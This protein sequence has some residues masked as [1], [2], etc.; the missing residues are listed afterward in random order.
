M[1]FFYI[2]IYFLIYCVKKP[3][4][5]G[6]NVSIKKF[7]FLSLIVKCNCKKLSYIAQIEIYYFHTSDR[8]NAKTERKY[9]ID[10]LDTATQKLE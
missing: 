4:Y 3:A 7:I 2:H 6:K 8:W 1:Y 5:L 9:D 10:R